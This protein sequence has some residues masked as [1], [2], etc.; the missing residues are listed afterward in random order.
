M[1]NEGGSASSSSATDG[2][3]GVGAEEGKWTIPSSLR[4]E[5]TAV[6]TAAGSL[7][8]TVWWMSPDMAESVNVTLACWSARPRDSPQNG[9]TF[10][11]ASTSFAQEGQKAM[12]VHAEVST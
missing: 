7:F 9:Q 4:A 3:G 6:V 8:T 10:H 11:V 12:P 2:A 1:A 5:I